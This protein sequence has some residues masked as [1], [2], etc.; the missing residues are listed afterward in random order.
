MLTGCASST[1]FANAQVNLAPLPPYVQG[2]GKIIKIPK[3][4]LDDKGTKKLIIELRKSEVNNARAVR[5]AKAHSRYTSKL[6]AQAPKQGPLVWP[7]DRPNYSP[8]NP[9]Q[10]EY[11]GLL[12]ELF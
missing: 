11:K 12:G 6:Y 4:P 5:I 2:Q 3:G 10:K 9:K 7:G 1:P 8:I